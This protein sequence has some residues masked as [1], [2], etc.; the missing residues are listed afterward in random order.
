VQYYIT[1]SFDKAVLL[2]SNIA[3][4]KI[5]EHLSSYT[6]CSGVRGPHSGLVTAMLMLRLILNVTLLT[7]VPAMHHEIVTINPLAPEFSFK[8]QM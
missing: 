6:T 1:H 8:F 4:H 7:V 5:I 2:Q 3:D